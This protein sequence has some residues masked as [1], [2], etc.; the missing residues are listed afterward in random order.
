MW[1]SAHCLGSRGDSGSLRWYATPRTT[2]LSGSSGRFPCAVI[3]TSQQRCE[4]WRELPIAYCMPHHR[5]TVEPVTNAR[6][7]CSPHSLPARVYHS[8]FPTF[9]PLAYMAT[10]WVKGSTRLDPR[11]RLHRGHGDVST[12]SGHCAISGSAAAAVL[13]SFV[14]R[15]STR[16]TD[17]RS[18]VCAAAIQC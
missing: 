14:L 1:P 11:G 6:E 15:A 16:P 4:G 5:R 9:P 17:C 7:S 18:S 13:Q 2:L 12:L 3:W 8:G 10:A